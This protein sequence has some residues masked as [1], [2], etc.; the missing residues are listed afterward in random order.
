[1]CFS[2]SERLSLLE[3]GKQSLHLFVVAHMGQGVLALGSVTVGPSLI[4]VQV[5]VTLGM[6]HEPSISKFANLHSH[7][8]FRT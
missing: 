6:V 5:T 7:T 3:V 1:M 8:F 4:P 2:C